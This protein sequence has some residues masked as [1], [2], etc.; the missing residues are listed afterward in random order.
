MLALADGKL[1]TC[2]LMFWAKQ[3]IRMHFIQGLSLKFLSIL[4]LYLNESDSS[5][6]NNWWYP[7]YYGIAF[8]GAIQSNIC[9][10]H[11][12]CLY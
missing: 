7:W 10:F 2:F 9:S 3:Q 1:L 11:F 5:G 8:A 4:D 6:D 12:V